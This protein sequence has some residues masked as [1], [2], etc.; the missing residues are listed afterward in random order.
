M[1]DEDIDDMY[2]GRA[3]RMFTRISDQPF[4]SID[5][6]T[7]R[8]YVCVRI[9]N[10]RVNEGVAEG[11]CEWQDP[12]ESRPDEM[13]DGIAIG[14]D[15]LDV[16]ED[17]WFDMYFHWYYVFEQSLVSRSLNGDDS[18]VPSFV[19]VTQRTRS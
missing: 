11:T 4:V 13:T 9:G 6:A 3:A 1:L 10:L 2:L 16:G 12:P 14:C 18:W 15:L 8:S 7:T 17:W 5:T 19:E